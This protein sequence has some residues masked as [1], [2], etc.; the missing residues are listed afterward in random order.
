M[1][2]STDSD[3]P[4]KI[5]ELKENIVVEEEKYQVDEDFEALLEDDEVFLERLR[6]SR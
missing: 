6:R 2:I 3:D 1:A 5:E 4:N